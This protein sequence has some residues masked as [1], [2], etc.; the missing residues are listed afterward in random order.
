MFYVM[1]TND[2][3]QKLITLH[4]NA[5]KT[6]YYKYLKKLLSNTRNYSH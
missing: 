3:D 5:N 6:F 4:D 1:C 2:T